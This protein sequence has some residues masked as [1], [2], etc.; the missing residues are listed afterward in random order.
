MGKKPKLLPHATVKVPEDLKA[1]RK[2][3]RI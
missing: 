3:N 1:K 2:K